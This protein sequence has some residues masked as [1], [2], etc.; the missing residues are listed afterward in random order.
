MAELLEERESL[1]SKIEEL[2]RQL[3]E[4]MTEQEGAAEDTERLKSRLEICQVF[5]PSRLHSP[6]LGYAVIQ[7]VSVNYKILKSKAAYK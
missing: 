4:L 2:E 5:T 3:K 6:T 7:C 1:M